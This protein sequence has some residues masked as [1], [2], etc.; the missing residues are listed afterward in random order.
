MRFYRMTLEGDVE[1][2]EHY[3]TA[4]TEA[5]DA[6]KAYYHKHQYGSVYIDLV[7]ADIN[8]GFSPIL[9]EFLL[10]RARLY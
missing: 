2:A 6:A 3:F 8:Q 10:K 4:L 1:A 7:E 5:H 9:L